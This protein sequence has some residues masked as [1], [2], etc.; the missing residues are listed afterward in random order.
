MSYV[1][2]Y[3]K[4]RP[5]TFAEVC[6]QEHIV[7]ALEASV[8]N[9]TI[10][11]AYL[12]CGSRGTGKT[13][14]A[15]IFAQAI[16]TN[17][18]DLYEMDGASNRGI[19]DVRA[20]RE[21]VNTLPF[22]SPYKV[23]IIDEV[24]MLT[25]DAFNALLKTLEEPPQHV[26]FI[27]ATTEFDKVIETVVSRCQV[28]TFKKP[29][30]KILKELVLTVAKKE[31]I[32][33]L[34]ASAELIAMLGEGSFRDALGI[35]EKV[36]TLQ[37]GTEPNAE[38]VEELVGAPR[39]ALVHALITAIT[40]RDLN[41]ALYTVHKAVDK[42]TDMRVFMR[43]LL[44]KMRALLLLRYSSAMEKELANELSIE[45]LTFLKKCA[46]SKDAYVNATVLRELLMA[47]ME[48]MPRA[49]IVELPL[50]LALMRLLGETDEKTLQPSIELR[51][52]VSA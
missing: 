37:S 24:H 35:L 22:R 40:E 2:L 21:A 29:S 28:F 41:T 32:T 33:L 25:K 49:A 47:Y 34:P 1:S 50:E 9:G 42:G 6:G 17:A 8:K 30:Q 5:R 11:H 52:V 45:E 14:I 3:R 23:Y 20:I 48:Q 36:L 43:L 44:H 10:S 13:S 4:Y 16:N 27:L 46:Q 7:S 26:I 51:N 19:D 38:E 18:E 31:G 39:G 15:R 12:F